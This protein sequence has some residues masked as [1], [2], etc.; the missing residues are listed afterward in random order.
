[1]G[2]A[3]GRRSQDRM[4]R[5][6]RPRADDRPGRVRIRRPLRS[7]AVRK[8]RRGVSVE[9]VTFG[10]RLN[11]YESEVIRRQAAA[12]GVEN[13]VVVNT[14]AGTAEAVRES[15]EAIRELK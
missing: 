1:D 8:G 10:C 12:R 13:T 3:G 5:A 14:C 11:A 9:V 6:R 15:G 2:D 7:R 4:A